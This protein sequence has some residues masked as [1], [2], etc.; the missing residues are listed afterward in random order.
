MS[1]TV[2]TVVVVG[3]GIVGLAT[4]RALQ[5]RGV[6][7]V[8]VLE[9]EE[10]LAVHQ[11]G[12]NSGVVHSGLFYR[13][14][15]VKARTCVRG[16]K[17]LYRFVREKGLPYRRS[18]KLVLATRADELSRLKALA[19]RGRANGLRSPQ[20]WSRARLRERCPDLAGVG[21]LLVRETGLVDFREVARALARDVVEEGGIVA[22]GRRVDRV[23]RD[24]PSLVVGTS[25]GEVRA[26]HLVGCAGLHADRL[27]RA[28]DV[29]TGGARVLPFRGR[30]YRV[31]KA[32][33]TL[34]ELPV[35]P[36]P[37]PEL[38]FLGVH[39]T[40]D[41]HGEVEVGPNA[42]MA[43]DR[44][45]Y[46]A[47]SVSGRELVEMFGFPGTWR[48][49]VRHWREA[50]REAASSASRRRFA[51]RARSLWPGLSE[52]ALERGRTGV[53]AQLVDRDGRFVDDF[54][55]VGDDRSLH[56]LNAPSPAATAALAI[57]DEVARRA[58][59]SW[60]MA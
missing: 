22:T 40:P 49:M 2:W 28:C 47:G 3:G 34:T 32:P 20:L 19:R 30:Y 24:G 26:R 27:A 11:T 51:T 6:D 21:A 14:G 7:R 48:L 56:V 17:A 60:S 29:D 13:P 15:T 52:A 39:F 38:P 58:A 16:R 43:L 1:R 35:Y 33:R 41:L 8:V 46:Q 50:I 42:V 12:H 18:G 36:V 10:E 59:E 9:A 57:G 44:E 37:D 55:I 25:G 5:R 45:G 4:A 53:R 31:A 54:R 23:V